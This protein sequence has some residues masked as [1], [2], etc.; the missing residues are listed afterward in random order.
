MHRSTRN[1]NL[2]NKDQR[3]WKKIWWSLFAEDKHAAAALGR[4]VHVR[5]RDCDLEPLDE[6]DFE[7]ESLPDVHIFGVQEKVHV[8]YVIFLSELS[9]ILERI[10]E[11]SFNPQDKV[12]SSLTEKFDECQTLLQDWEARLPAELRRCDCLWT[13]NLHIAYK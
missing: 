8:S 4:P 13:N 2:S 7:E 10:V 9:K 12:P 5:L 6:S 1:S 11:Q 3:L